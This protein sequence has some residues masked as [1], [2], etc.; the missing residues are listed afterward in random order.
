MY[1]CFVVSRGK[2]FIFLRDSRLG[3]LGR[4]LIMLFCRCLY[5]DV[6]LFFVKLSLKNNFCI[7]NNCW[8][9]WVFS[10][11]MPGSLDMYVI[12]IGGAAGYLAFYIYLVILSWTLWTGIYLKF[13]HK[14][15]AL[16]QIAQNFIICDSLKESAAAE[17]Y[18][19]L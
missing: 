15:N 16:D 19:S 6:V 7:R 3:K 1:C 13:V 9:F 4:G 11:G 5:F 8:Y 17:D 10:R 2:R 18:L 12:C 14:Y